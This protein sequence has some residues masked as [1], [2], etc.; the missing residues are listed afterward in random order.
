[1]GSAT[2]TDQHIRE[3]RGMIMTDVTICG[4][5]DGREYGVSSSRKYRWLTDGYIL[6]RRTIGGDGEFLPVDT[7]VYRQQGQALMALYCGVGIVQGFRTA[8]GAP[9]P[10]VKQ[11]SLFDIGQ[12]EQQTSL[13]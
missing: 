11:G 5:L 3:E 13:F 1:M 10:F 12:T 6:V 7:F 2:T 8:D 4:T 9:P